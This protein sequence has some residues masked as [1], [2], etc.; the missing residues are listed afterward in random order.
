[1]HLDETMGGLPG[2]GEEEIVKE[3]QQGEG[4]TRPKQ[5]RRTFA[6]VLKEDSYKVLRQEREQQKKKKAARAMA[7]QERKEKEKATLVMKNVSQR[8]TGQRGCMIS[9]LREGHLQ[10]CTLL[11]HRRYMLPK[12]THYMIA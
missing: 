2:I 10:R 11:L 3:Q 1:M 8:N 7:E 12:H 5:I 4:E 9:G 6:Q